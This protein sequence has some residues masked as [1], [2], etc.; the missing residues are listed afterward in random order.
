MLEKF[1]QIFTSWWVLA[2]IVLLQMLVLIFA[3]NEQ[4]LG[5]GIKPVYLH[6]SLTWVGM[7]F[8]LISGIVGLVLFFYHSE[9][10]ARWHRAIFL[11][12]LVFY[13]VGF[14]ISMYASWIN[15]GGIPFQEP[16][17]RNTV[18]VVVVAVA[19]WIFSELVRNFRVQAVAGIL[20]LVFILLARG[21]D[22]MVLHPDNPVSTAPMSIRSTFL[23][24]FGLAI[25]LSLWVFI[26][27]L[28]NRSKV[29]HQGIP[30]Q[31]EA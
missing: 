20:P 4:T 30:G 12:A 18:N 7:I 8:F 24:M 27:L 3:P 2:V 16:R 14:L 5:A 10:L 6:V 22:R 13:I 23:I 25:V 19:A 9:K 11:N 26:K 28:F 31:T 1:K 17:I 21:S 15:W 29:V